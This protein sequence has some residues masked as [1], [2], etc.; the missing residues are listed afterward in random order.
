MSALRAGLCA[1]AWCA[2]ASAGADTLDVH[3]ALSARAAAASGPPGWI[4][5][6]FGRLTEGGSGGETRTLF[7]GEGQLG[8]D[9]RPG[10]AWLLRVHASAHGEP[11]S[12]GGQRAGLT[13]A[14]LQFRPELTA[15]ASLRLRAGLFFP[16]T[17][18]ENVDPL[19]QSPYT[20]TLSA[21]NAWIGEELRLSGAD[22]AVVLQG[23][24]NRIELGGA[25]FGAADTSGALLAWRGF[26]FGDR[27]ST[28]GET[29]PLPPLVT[30]GPGGAFADQRDDGTRP[31][32]ELDERVGWHARARVA[33]ERAVRLQAAWTDNRGDRAL[34]RGQYAWRTRLAQAGLELNLGSSVLLLAEAAA[35]DTGMGPAVVD[36]PRVD[37]RFRVGY[38]LVSWRAGRLRVSGRV[39]AWDGDDRDG[40]AEPNGESGWSA[41]SAVFYQPARVL[42]LGAEYVAVRADRDAAAFSGAARS[43]DADRATVELRFVF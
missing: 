4:A 29:L 38:V 3:A 20:I 32:D 30:L 15:R 17:S 41:T 7:R 40:T 21:L 18:L 16:P 25:A 22:A 28:F 9:W 39:D 8:V 33:R 34:H 13:E 37:L 5:G 23:E 24:R 2:S 26:A 36:G 11:S 6:G 31:V 1:L 43:T 27:L 10:E 14:F 35:G 12:A 19:W 42:R